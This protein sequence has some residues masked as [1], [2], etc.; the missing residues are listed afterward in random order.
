MRII[1]PMKYF[2]TIFI[3]LFVIISFSCL[4]AWQGIYLAKEPGSSQSV[5]FL[6]EKGEGAKEISVNLKKQELIK[7]SSLFR[8]YAL[9]QGKAGKL[10]AGEYELSSAMNIPEIVEKL[11]S[12]EAIKATITVIE[13]WNLRDIGNYFEKKGMFTAEELFELVGFPLIDYSKVTGL[14]PPKDFSGELNFLKDKPKNIGLEG[15]LFP[16]TYH[17][18]GQRTEN[19][20]Q[21]L[22]NI[23]RKMLTNFG[24]KLTPDLIKEITNQ[25]KSIFEIVTMASLIEKEVRIIEDM[26]IVSGIL[27]KRLDVGMPLQSCATIVYITGKKTTSVSIAETE[28]DSPYNTYK[29]KGLPKGPI[30]NPGFNSLEAAIFPEASDY[31][32]YLSTPEGETIF[33][34][35][36]KEH[37]IAKAKYLK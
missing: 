34:K 14:P 1:V 32:Y 5:T 13:G 15:Y 33:S 27:W 31:W 9:V 4:F 35:T 6:V 12:G 21:K 7:Y 8:V 16:D 17:I 11:A 20:E 28:I 2:L 36:L 30:S 23:V 10:Q 26:K 25:N 24:E 3:L 37:D 22:E 29:Y 18:N 19:N